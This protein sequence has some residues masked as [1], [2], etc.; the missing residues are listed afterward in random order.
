MCCFTI[1]I[2]C[3]WLIGSTG[4]NISRFAWHALTD[5]QSTKI[6]VFTVL[7]FLHMLALGDSF[8]GAAEGFRFRARQFFAR[9]QRIEGSS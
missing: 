3:A 6:D 5:K 4:G 9:E 1:S 8:D 7:R 2:I